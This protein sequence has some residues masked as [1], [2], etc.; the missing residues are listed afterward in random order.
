MIPVL[1]AKWKDRRFGLF[2]QDIDETLLCPKLELPPIESR[3]I[4]GYFQYQHD[5]IPVVAGSTLVGEG[6]QELGLY[7]ILVLTSNPRRWAL[8]VHVVEGIVRI[9]WKDVQPSKTLQDK[10]PGLMGELT[11][12]DGVLPI[13]VMPQVLLSL[14]K[15]VMARSEK[16]IKDRES[17]ATLALKECELE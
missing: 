11:R 15:E 16:L 6:Q 14:E 2:A 12:D 17:R 3:I 7:D 8:R 4:E 13:F 5:W 1:L 9:D 10:T